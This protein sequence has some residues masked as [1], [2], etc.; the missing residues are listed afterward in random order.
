MQ[1]KQGDTEMLIEQ[2]IQKR[3]ESYEPDPRVHTF[4]IRLNTADNTLLNNLAGYFGW[5]KTRLAEALL[6][7]AM[8]DATRRIAASHANGDPQKESD[9]HAMFYQ[10]QGVEPGVDSL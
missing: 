1:N 3:Q 8:E 7:S 9:I 10:P 6:H 4:S 2:L 5:K